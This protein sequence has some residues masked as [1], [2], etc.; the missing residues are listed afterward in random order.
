M[1]WWSRFAVVMTFLG[2]TV[3]GAACG[4]LVSPVP[5]HPGSETPTPPPTEPP[6]PTPAITPYPPP[7]V[8]PTVPVYPTGPRPTSTPTPVPTATPLPTALPLPPSG[9]DILWVETAYDWPAGP[10]GTI[11]RADPRDIAHRRE[12]VHF[13]D[14]AIFQAA[15]SPNGRQVAFTAAGRRWRTTPLW[16]VNLDGSELRQ[17]VPDAGVIFW[18]RDN[19]AIYYSLWVEQEEVYGLERVDLVSGEVQPI[20]AVEPPG[21]DHLL[22]WSA[23]GQWFYYTLPRPAP[24]KDELWR[25]RYDGSAAEFITSLPE[26]RVEWDR[27]RLSP[28]G[29]KLLLGTH[30]IST[31]GQEEGDIQHPPGSVF[32]VIWG[33]GENEVIVGQRAQDLYHLYAINLRSQH[34]REL[35][36]F[37]IAAD[38]GW[39][40]LALSPDHHWLMAQVAYY[41]GSYWIHLPTG[42]MVPIPSCQ[43]CEVRFVG[44]V[45]RGREP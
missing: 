18:T 41:D 9:F 12:V 13:D 19:R 32:D 26:I 23:G 4:S 36:T 31:D 28:N 24:E 37:A 39:Y 45:P 16:V 42:M 20:L 6:L 17:L 5:A 10:S 35:A 33:E 40:H 2:L 25:V 27:V 43:G 30:W 29:S 8:E 21:F 22:G 7:T 1:K 14:Q 11:W 44:W 3:W 15:L 38:F 34:V